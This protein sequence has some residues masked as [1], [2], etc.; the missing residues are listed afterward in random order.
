MFT[1]LKADQHPNGT[2]VCIHCGEKNKSL[3]SNFGGDEVGLN[4]CIACSKIIDKYIE[5]DLLL[6]IIDILLHRSTIYRHLILNRFSC[7][8][9]KDIYLFCLWILLISSCFES[10][11]FYLYY[12]NILNI[13]MN[14]IGYLNVFIFV[15]LMKLIRFGTIITFS[16]ML[17]NDV[18]IESLFLA[19]TLSSIGWLFIII[20]IIWKYQ[21]IFIFIIALFVIT[22]NIASVNVINN[23][24]P[25]SL[26]SVI[27]GWLAV[28]FY[29]LKTP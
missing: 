2:F 20:L 10:I 19:L 8:N 28:I 21:T 4:K 24:L 14:D 23:N 13:N 7:L 25:I 12:K 18:S 26:L 17:I 27:S 3:Y 6:I 9:K 16:T 29:G 5:Y 1:V 15:L 22:S 11:A